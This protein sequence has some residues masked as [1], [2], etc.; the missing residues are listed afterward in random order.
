MAEL[1]G[2]Q[3]TEVNSQRK[4][5]A[6]LTTRYSK[7]FEWLLDDFQVAEGEDVRQEKHGAVEVIS[8]SACSTGLIGAVLG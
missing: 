2:R 4:T 6:M 1:Q 3:C 7:R 8:I 5:W